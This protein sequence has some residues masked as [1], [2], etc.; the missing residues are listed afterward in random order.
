MRSDTALFLLSRRRATGRETFEN[1]R[2]NLLTSAAAVLQEE[3]GDGLK[4]REVR[5]INDRAAVPFGRDEIGSRQHGKM[6]GQRVLRH[7]KQS[8]EIAGGQSVRFM[9]HQRPECLKTGLLGE[10]AK[11]QDGLFIF[12]ISRYMEISETVNSCR[13]NWADD[14]SNILEI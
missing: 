9:L 6:G 11:R 1:G 3:D 5:A 13:R 10:G 8:G 4:R 7:F 14:I 12:H 2:A